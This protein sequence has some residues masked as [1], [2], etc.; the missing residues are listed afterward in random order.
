MAATREEVDGWIKEAKENSI[1]Y[2]I[3]VCDTFDFD[4]YPV[5]CKGIKE[6]D[7]KFVFYDGVNMQKVNEIIRINA[8]GSVDENLNLIDRKIKTQ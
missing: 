7:E 1:G 6:L 4:D 5:F 8:D 3:S 2:I